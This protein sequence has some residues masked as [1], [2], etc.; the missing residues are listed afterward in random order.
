M[1]DPKRII[2]LISTSGNWE[3]FTRI[4]GLAAAL[5]EH[6]HSSVIAAPEH[7]RLREMAEGAGVEVLDYEPGRSINP[8]RWKELAAVVRKNDAGIVHAHDAGTASL[9]SRAGLFLDNPRIV[10][11]RYDME[12]G[13]SGTECGSKVD[14]VVCSSQKMADAYRA[15]GTAAEKIHVVFAGA[16]LAIAE[17]S[18]EGRAD[19]RSFFREQYCPGNEKPLFIASIAPFDANG[20]QREL[21]E[22]MPEVLAALPQTHLF[23]MG[24][25]ADREE[26]QRQ[27]KLLAVSG[28]V[29]LL[30]PEKAYH[31]LLAAADLYVGWAKEDYAGIMVQTAMAAGRGT[32]LR[33]SGC[34]GELG[35]DGASAVFADGNSPDSLKNTLLAIL[36]DRLRRERLGKQAKARAMQRFNA[37]DCASALADIYSGMAKR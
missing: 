13:V 16:N 26:L 24:E 33:D 8:L 18:E 12:G 14:A 27:I 29:T 6:G 32:L 21:I 23:L 37:R 10:V 3:P 5:R 34:S 19:I 1:A 30:E 7:S 25:G 36:G 2:H 35:E 31:R 28:E 4:V 22:A 20:S 9:V 11:S 15:A 17:R